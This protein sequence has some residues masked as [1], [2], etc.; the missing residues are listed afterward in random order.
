VP[1]R[2]PKPPHERLTLT[3]PVLNR[4]RC[5]L[6]LVSGAAKAEPLAAVLEGPRDPERLPSQGVAPSDGALVWLVDAA[7]AARLSGD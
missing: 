4:A 7:A 1:A 6:F 3:F 2:S 5:A